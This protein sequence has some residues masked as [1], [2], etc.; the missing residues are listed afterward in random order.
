MSWPVSNSYGVQM[1]QAADDNE[2]ARKS[3]EEKRESDNHFRLEGDAIRA[4]NELRQKFALSLAVGNGGALLALF[5]ALLSDKRPW[6]LLPCGVF[7]LAGVL[8]AGP[9]PYALSRMFFYTSEV[10]WIVGRRVVK[11][12]KISEDGNTYTSDEYYEL[13]NDL[14]HKWMKRVN[15]LEWGSGIAFGA[16]GAVGLLLLTA[17]LFRLT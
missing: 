5:T 13:K 15:C 14:R 1:T 3:D 12:F 17:K 11:D 6:E 9:I 2:I 7:F 4:S 8:F 16:G 10:H